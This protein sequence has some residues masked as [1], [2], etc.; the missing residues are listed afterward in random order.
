MSKPK[1]RQGPATQPGMKEVFT[2]QS[3]IALLSY[4]F[5]ALHSVAYDQVLPVFLNYPVEEHTPENTSFPIGFTGGFGLE[6]GKIGSI[7]MVYGI[8]CGLIQFILFPPLCTYFGSQKLI[9]ACSKQSPY[10]HLPPLTPSFFTNKNQP[11]SS[12]SCTS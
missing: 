9:R 4:T 1:K 12:R 8:T 11:S 10:P 3:S 7:F 6:S 5:L 2:P